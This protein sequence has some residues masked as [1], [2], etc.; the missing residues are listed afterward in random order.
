M[1]EKRSLKEI[2]FGKKK[3]Q[4]QNYYKMEMLNG[5]DTFFTTISDVTD[6]KIVMQCIDRIA[7]HGAK[8]MPRHIQE[9]GDSTRNINGDINYLLQHQPNPIMNRYIFEYKVLATLEANNNSFVWIAKNR[10]GFITGFYPILATE[11]DLLQ[12]KT[13][14]IYLRFKFING[15]IYTLPYNELIHLR[16]FYYKNDI[17]GTSNRA[18]RT[19]VETAQTSSEG[20]KNAVQLSNKVKGL[21]H[22]TNSMLKPEDLQIAKERFVKDFL[23]LENRSGIVA[24]D[25]KAT[26]QELNIKPIM[27]DSDQLKMVNNNIYDYFGISENIIK[28]DFLPNQWNAFFEGVIE[29]LA[30]QMSEEFTNKVFNDES[31]RNGH[32]IVFTA[33]R[34]QYAD[35]NS[36][37]KLLQVTLPYGLLTKDTA[38]ELLDLPTIRRR[39]RSKDITIIEQYK[40]SYC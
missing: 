14:T 16:K 37:I 22:F 12:D 13:G 18:L 39:R 30:I 9:V 19:D 27:L 36:K 6:T 11:E 2:I 29:P 31:I 10:Q 3:P 5:S 8:L 24:L 32:K 28:N 25:G 4:E 7:T 40:F 34:L 38:L 1:K 17:F 26:F 21:L 20:T 33:N 15:Q 35:I 23:S